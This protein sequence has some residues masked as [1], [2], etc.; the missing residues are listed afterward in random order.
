MIQLAKM[1]NSIYIYFQ[2][3]GILESHGQ[4]LENF[5]N[6]IAVQ[7]RYLAFTKDFEWLANVTVLGQNSLNSSQVQYA[8]TCKIQRV[9][10]SYLVWRIP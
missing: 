6:L 1:K 7:V 5:Q 8:K 4:L 3:I 10:K 2:E 9:Y